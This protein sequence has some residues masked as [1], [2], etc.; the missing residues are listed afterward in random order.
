MFKQIPRKDGI[1]Y[2]VLKLL[3]INKKMAVASTAQS[4]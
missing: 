2:R 1:Y 4:P 3:L